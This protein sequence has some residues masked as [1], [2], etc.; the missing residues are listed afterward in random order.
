[1]ELSHHF[2]CNQYSRIGRARKFESLTI[3]G[4]GM[5]GGMSSTDISSN[6]LRVCG[7]DKEVW[8]QLVIRRQLQKRTEA[9]FT[10]G[11]KVL[12]EIDNSIFQGRLW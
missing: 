11:H 10:A 12:R 5:F 9:S 1:M 2:L 3:A 8:G 4:N 6:V 7:L